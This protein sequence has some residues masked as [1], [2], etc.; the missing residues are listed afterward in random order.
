[1]ALRNASNVEKPLNV[2]RTPPGYKGVVTVRVLEEKFGKSSGGLPMITLETEIL[3]PKSVKSDLDGGAE[4]DISGMKVPMWIML[5]ERNGK[6]EPSP[7]LNNFINDTLPKLGLPQQFDDS[8]PLFHEE[9]NPNGLKFKGLCF[10]IM[11]DTD[12]RIERSKGAD[13]KYTDVIDPDT[14]KPLS[15]GWQFTANSRDILRK[16]D[17]PTE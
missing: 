3:S 4:Y 5:N 14:N 17:A 11:L 9:K 10:R 12:E 8:D 6:G 13:G 7:N 1:M 2:G 15:K 16:V